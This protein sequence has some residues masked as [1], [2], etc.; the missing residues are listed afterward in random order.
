MRRLVAQISTVSVNV[1]SLCSTL[2]V[3]LNLAFTSSCITS[4][5]KSLPVFEAAVKFLLP[6]SQNYLNEADTDDED[7]KCENVSSPEEVAEAQSKCLE[8]KGAL[9]FSRIDEIFVFSKDLNIIASFKL[10]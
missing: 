1:S 10:L 6:M 4:S 7:E 8:L 5:N 9:V 2:H 3:T